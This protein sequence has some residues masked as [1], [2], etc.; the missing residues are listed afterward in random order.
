MNDNLLQSKTKESKETKLNKTTPSLLTL[1]LS[2][3]LSKIKQNII[4]IIII[5]SLEVIVPDA[6]VM[7]TENFQP[8]WVWDCLLLREFSERQR[9]LFSLSNPSVYTNTI[10]EI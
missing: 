6:L 7:G 10:L 5:V 3:S 2:L 4:I 1:S 9:L 8:L